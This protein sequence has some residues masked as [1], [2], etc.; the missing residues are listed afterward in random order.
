MVNITIS[1]TE[2]VFEKKEKVRQSNMFNYCRYCFSEA[3]I[4]KNELINRS[5]PSGSANSAL[6]QLCYSI[7]K[8]NQQDLGYERYQQAWY[9]GL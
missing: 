8:E 1:E 6:R 5:K 9:I 4:L 3:P 2:W 7:I